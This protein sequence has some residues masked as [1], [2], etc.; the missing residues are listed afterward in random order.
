MTKQIRIS[1]LLLLFITLTF[2]I[3]QLDADPP[4]DFSWSGGYFADEGFWSHN[5]RNA[6]LFGNAVQDEW[7]ARIVSPVFARMQQWIFQLFGSGFIQVRLIAVF[8]S[9][10]L[11]GSAFLLFRKELD[12]QASFFFAILASLNYPML[13]L[14]RQGILDP[15]A[16]A[17]CLLSLA[18]VMRDSKWLEFLAGLL[19]VV[20]CVTKYLLIYAIVPFAYLL[21]SSRKFF[22]FVSGV[23]AAGLLWIFFNYLPHRELLSA[24]NAYYASQQSWELTAVLKNIVT[25]P[26]YLYFVKTPA[27]LCFAN[28]GIWAFLSRNGSQT[29]PR[30]ST[31]K[32]CFLWLVSGILFFALWKYR[33]MRYYT[34]LIPPMAAMAGFALIGLKEITRTWNTMKWRYLL[35]AGLLLPVVQ[36]LFVLI[37]RLAGWNFVPSQLGIHPLDI[38][39]FLI[40]S[41]ILIWS[42]RSGDSKVKYAAWAFV[43]VLFLSDLRAYLTWMLKPQHAS[44]EIAKDLER[45]APN[46]VITGQWGPE[47]CLPNRLRVIPIWRGFVNSKASLQ[48][49]GITHILQWKYPLGGE[50][51]EEWYPEDFKRF[52]FVTKYRIK[53]SDLILYERKE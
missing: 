26:F 10:I 11:A 52:Q 24:Y 1:F 37:D 29:R 23:A 2:R 4:S 38:V 42:I 28:L 18:L 53:D 30:L 12:P 41:A 44:M 46:G 48:E 21:W 8:S 25:Q 51:F 17:I 6:V 5:A 20:A 49:L 47:L 19:F 3:F 39:L 22:P 43:A 31:E 45:R 36:L 13:V 50:K 34:S 15:F 7:D 35:Y 33:P 27:L 9:L 40:L 32:I 16:A 14:G